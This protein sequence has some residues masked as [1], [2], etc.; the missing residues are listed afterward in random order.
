[1]TNIGI[2]VIG[3]G[4]IGTGVSLRFQT[5]QKYDLKWI[6]DINLESA[7]KLAKERDTKA[8]SNLEDVLGDPAV[9]IVYI[10]VPPIHHK[11]LTVKAFDAGKHVF[12]EKPIAHS[13]EDALEMV[14]AQVKSGRAGCINLQVEFARNIQK[15]NKLLS[16]NTIGNILKIQMWYR[17]PVW[18]REWQTVDWVNTQLQGGPIREVGTHLIHTLMKMSDWIGKPKK[19]LSA[20]TY[21]DETTSEKALSGMIITD[22]EIQI[23]VDATVG[24][25]EDEIQ[26]YTIYGEKG[27]ITLKDFSELIVKTKSKEEKFIATRE[28]FLSGAD[29][30]FNNIAAAVENPSLEQGIVTFKSA[31]ET[32]RVIVALLNSNEQ[33]I[34]L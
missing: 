1:M 2:A 8:T 25:I 16:E 14:E 30:H 34:T 20:V 15:A 4:A 10:A 24:G 33:W 9:N 31:Y 26:A 6:C 11:E 29:L 28:D 17:Y 18:P 7:Q 21:P 23:Q 32:N 5:H 22:K 27:S 19:V 12:C 3:A 13:N